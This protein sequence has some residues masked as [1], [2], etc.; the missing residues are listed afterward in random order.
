MEIRQLT[1]KDFD[2]YREISYRSYPSIRDFSPQGYQDYD[3]SV[4][5]LMEG[6]NEE[7]FF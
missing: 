5:A 6:Q 3:Q 7:L 2:K 1:L 4:Q